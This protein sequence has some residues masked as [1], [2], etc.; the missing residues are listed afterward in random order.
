MGILYWDND[1]PKIATQRSFKNP[2]AV[3]ATEILHKKYQHTFKNLTKKYSYIFEIIY[4]DT[5]VLVDYGNE[6]K[7]VLLG[8]LDLKT[9]KELKINE[10][11]GFPVAKD[12]T[13]EYAHIHNL[14]DLKKMDLKN[15][16]GFVLTYNSGLKVKLKFSWYDKSH[17]IMAEMIMTEL[18]LLN[19]RK[20]FKES[21]GIKEK[22]IKYNELDKDLISTIVKG[23]L[24]KIPTAFLQNGFEQWLLNPNRTENFIVEN[25]LTKPE[26]CTYMWKYIQS[27]KN[28]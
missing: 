1:V 14:A 6:E 18:H 7:I 5:S 19:K 15:V 22:P 27:I 20:E 16:E 13:K 9:G 12:Y 28:R 10:S 25:T 23:N 21:L 17:K 24:R 8:I 4:P 11:I 3:K 2:N 26:H